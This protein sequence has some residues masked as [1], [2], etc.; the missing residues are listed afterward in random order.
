MAD[1]ILLVGGGAA[2]FDR[3]RPAAVSGIV[4][5]PDPQYAN[6]RGMWKL[7]LYQMTREMAAGGAA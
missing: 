6:V 5:P 4:V 2:V 1:L 3:A 7:G